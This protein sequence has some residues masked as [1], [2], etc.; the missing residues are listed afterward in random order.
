MKC[1]YCVKVEKKGKVIFM[2]NRQSKFLKIFYPTFITSSIYFAKNCVS[3]IY[4]PKT[5]E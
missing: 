4:H 2:D 5:K 1:C 3:N